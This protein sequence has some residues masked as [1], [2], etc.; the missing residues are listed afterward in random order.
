MKKE[1]KMD[2]RVGFGTTSLLEQF[3][4]EYIDAFTT[5]GKSGQLIYTGDIRYLSVY[6]SLK[7]YNSKEKQ[8]NKQNAN[9]Y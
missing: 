7:A 5:T 6:N 1:Y 4:K 9:A 3:V 8:R 2:G